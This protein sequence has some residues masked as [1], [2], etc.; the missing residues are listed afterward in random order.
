MAAEKQQ[1]RDVWLKIV[2]EANAFGENDKTEF[3]TE[4]TA[5]WDGDIPC[6][7]YKETEVSGM[8]GTMATVK[9]EGD[10]VS[11]I[12][13]GQINA[14]MVF[15]TGKSS[16]A[17]YSTPVGDIPMTITT[18]DVQVDYAKDTNTDDAPK[19]MLTGIHMAYR[20]TMQGQE[21]SRNTMTITVQ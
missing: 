13:I 15:E 7:S 14:M 16:L 10:K 17:M 21:S 19:K 8:P 18:D 5:Y 12:R 2:G 20:I 1:T 4:G 3:M 11:V 6:L 9:V